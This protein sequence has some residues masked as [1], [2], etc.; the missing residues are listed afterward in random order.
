MLRCDIARCHMH[1]PSLIIIPP[2]R[3]II[4]TSPT[5]QL[6]PC[7]LTSPTIARL[8]YTVTPATSALSQP[9]CCSHHA[10]VIL[11]L[12]IVSCSS[13]NSLSSTPPHRCSHPARA[14]LRL[15][16]LSSVLHLPASPSF[17]SNRVITPTSVLLQHP[18]HPQLTRLPLPHI[19]LTPHASQ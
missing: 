9:R 1:L 5:S 13:E 12:H 11:T 17:A 10:H 15:F 4:H 18:C 19:I 3:N 16:S 7:T 14:T 8:N 2:D 6:R